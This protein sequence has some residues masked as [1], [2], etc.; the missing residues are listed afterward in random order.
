MAPRIPILKPTARCQCLGVGAAVEFVEVE[1]TLALRTE[2][3]TRGD[4]DVGLAGRFVECLPTR[5]ALE[6]KVSHSLAWA[7]K[8]IEVAMP[9]RNR[10]QSDLRSSLRRQGERHSGDLRAVTAESFHIGPGVVEDP[11]ARAKKIATLDKK[12]IR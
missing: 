8:R 1:E 9:S 12:F 4:H 5:D 10:P 6:I 7:V 11:A 2:A 3:A